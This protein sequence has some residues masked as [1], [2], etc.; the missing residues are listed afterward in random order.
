MPDLSEV[1]SIIKGSID[2]VRRDYL[3]ELHILTKYDTILYASKFSTPTQI[4][5]FLISI[6]DQDI[7]HFMSVLNGLKGDKLDLILHSPGG[8]INS[9][10]Q[11][12]QYLRRKYRYIRAIIPQNAMSAATMIACA[13]D[14]IV[15]GKHS[16]L[17]PTD[18]IINMP[19]NSVA[20]QSI[21]NEFEKAKAEI[22]QDSRNIPIWAP[23]IANWPPG[24]LSECERS[25]ALSKD[26]VETWLCT[27]M[28]KNKANAKAKKIAAYLANANE[29]KTHGRP[30]GI[31]V[32]SKQGLK[33]K[34]LEENQNLQEKVLSV[35]HA[36]TVTFETTN[37]IKIIENHDGKGVHTQA[38]ITPI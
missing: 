23:I 12:V 33:V 21:L 38:N 31:D 20:A 14:E 6:N 9:A 15:M 2:Q 13:A 25:L 19:P 37:C 16:A 3:R 29:H 30:L 10:D 1:R 22:I 34:P 35:F 26:R 11:I 4:P 8:S 24:L 17:G 18:P 36:S 28:F 7:Q 32:L 27:Y 5:G